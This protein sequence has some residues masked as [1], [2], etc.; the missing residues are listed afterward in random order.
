MAKIKP[1]PKKTNKYHI[2]FK[3]FLAMGKNDP[4]ILPVEHFR[5]FK[6]QKQ[7]EETDH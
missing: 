3:S 1:I 7:T 5:A 6:L 2:S 4:L